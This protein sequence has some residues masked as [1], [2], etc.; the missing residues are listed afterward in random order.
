MAKT[1][2]AVVKSWRLRNPEKRKEQG[3]R[4]R[5][6]Y[7]EKVNARAKS[8]RDRNPEKVAAHTR[9][10]R[11]RKYL[12]LYEYQVAIGCMV[13][14]ENDFRCTEFHHRDP[15]KKEFNIAG[16]VASYSLEKI[17]NEVGKCDVVCAN[18]HRI[19]HYEEKKNDSI[20]RQEV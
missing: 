1:N 19:L 11:G 6:R 10:W 7:P 16:A 5:E 14:G 3:R 18:C 8:W 15:S 9:D 4:Y 12:W 2:Y 13:C 20:P 17:I